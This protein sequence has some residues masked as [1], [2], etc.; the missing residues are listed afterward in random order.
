MLVS[1]QTL[2]THATDPDWIVFDC[3]HDL[4]NAGKGESM[5]REG[6]VPG[7]FFANLDTDLSG[8]KTG[9][10][11]RHPLPSPAAFSAFLARH[12][13]TER[14]T[15]VAYDDVGGQFAA[16]LWWLCRWVGLRNVSLLDGGVQN[17]V[18]AG[19][20]LHTAIPQTR[21]SPF[22]GRSD[23]LMVVG[24]NELL[25]RV[26]QSGLTLIDARAPE[27]YRGEVEPID[28]VAGHIPGAVNR[29]YK[30]NLNVDLTMKAPDVLRDAFANIVEAGS[31]VVHQCGSGVTACANIFAMEYAG[32]TG[33][34]LYAGSWSEWIADP[35]RPVVVETASVVSEK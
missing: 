34:R 21:R 4:M 30:E 35:S 5:Y 29:F 6:H 13:V 11:G 23:A 19:H 3:R 26:N 14:S 17:W 1:P 31:E 28:P 25:H 22:A 18:A 10:N 32:L 9:L 2:A 16:R 7:A 12:G 27:R 20:T 33:S 24:V 15:V 8:E